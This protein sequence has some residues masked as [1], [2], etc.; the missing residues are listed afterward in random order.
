MKRKI[1]KTVKQIC[2]K[3]RRVLIGL[4]HSDIG[5]K[6]DGCDC[7]FCQPITQQSINVK[8]DGDGEEIQN[9]DMWK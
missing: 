1:D 3:Y 9:F 8:G 5:K 4:A 6:Q 2:T 7:C